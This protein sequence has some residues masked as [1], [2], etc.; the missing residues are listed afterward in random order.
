M[1]L[2]SLRTRERRGRIR[3]APPP[4][5]GCAHRF[6]RMGGRGVSAQHRRLRDT[7]HR[8]CALAAQHSRRPR[9]RSAFSRAH[10]R[11]AST[12]GA[13]LRTRART[14]RVGAHESGR[15]CFFCFFF[16]SFC[17]C[18]FFCVCLFV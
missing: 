5:R 2:E 16:C 12:R 3:A 1:P 17:C 18:F 13:P 7:A 6:V 4:G 9:Q 10:R 15:E 14:R 11:A 8:P